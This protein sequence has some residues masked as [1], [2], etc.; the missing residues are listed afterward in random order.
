MKR[1]RP[2]I[3]DVVQLTLP[4][5]TFAYGRVLRDTSVAFYRE[6]TSDPGEPPIGSRDYQF[7]VGVYN[8]VFKSSKTAIIGHD[9]SRDAEDEWPPPYSVRDHLTRRVSVYYKGKLRPAEEDEVRGLE[10]AAVWA[11]DHLTDR[12]VGKQRGN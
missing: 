2:A 5:G 4:N 8:D 10:P 3:G 11:L 12:L 7:V 9:P 6:T 1:S